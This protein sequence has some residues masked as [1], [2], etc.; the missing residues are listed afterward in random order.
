MSAISMPLIHFNNLQDTSLGYVKNPDGFPDL[1]LP[2]HLLCTSFETGRRT[3]A[4]V[5]QL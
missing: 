5:I 3:L 2:Y 4:M 1:P